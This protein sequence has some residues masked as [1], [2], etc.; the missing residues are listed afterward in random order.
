MRCFVQWLEYEMPFRTWQ[1]NKENKPSHVIK[2][3]VAN[4]H[5][6][7]GGQKFRIVGVGKKMKF[8]AFDLDRRIWVQQKCCEDGTRQTSASEVRRYVQTMKQTLSHR[9]VCDSLD[10]P[11]RNWPL[12]ASVGRTVHLI[13]CRQN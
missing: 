11:S 1:G 10:S 3:A 2:S 4:V 9:P 5:R 13:L 7:K 8:N 6:I 12:S